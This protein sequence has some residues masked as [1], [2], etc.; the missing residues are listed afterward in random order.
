VQGDRDHSDGG[1]PEVPVKSA[2]G[3]DALDPRILPEMG[4]RWAFRRDECR[5]DG[6]SR[7]IVPKGG[8][9][10]KQARSARRRVPRSRTRRCAPFHGTRPSDD[11]RATSRRVGI[12]LRESPPHSHFRQDAWI[13]R[14]KTHAH[15]DVDF[16][17]SAVGMIAITLHESSTQDTAIEHARPLGPTRLD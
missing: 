1:P 16:W 13:E 11:Y 7:G 9:S 3:F 15:F 14:V 4:V 12:R 2:R 6:W 8:T 5:H 17:R 10:L